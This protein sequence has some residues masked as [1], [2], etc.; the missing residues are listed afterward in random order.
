MASVSSTCGA[1]A[2]GAAVGGIGVSV[3]GTGVLVGGRGVGVGVAAG[4]Q[5]LT[6]MTNK[7]TN[8]K[9]FIAVYLAF[10]LGVGKGNLQR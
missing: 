10:W 2:A 3:G 8:D 5:A 1:A 4:A 6:T 7:R 9:A